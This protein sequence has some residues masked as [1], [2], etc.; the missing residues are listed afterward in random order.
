MKAEIGEFQRSML[1]LYLK[2]FDFLTSQVEWLEAKLVEHM[3]P[4]AQQVKLLD[5]IPGID[6]I[7]AWNLLAE[8]GPDM[9]V[10]PD[11][12]HCASWAGLSPGTEESAGVQRSGR[13]TKGNRYLRRILTQAAWANSHCKDGYL[14]TFFF[15]VKARR[16]W[17]RA[18][19]AVAHKLLVIAYNMLK[20]GEAYKELG[21]DY[22][23]RLHPERTAMRLVA[24]LEK[25]GYTFAAPPI[26][27]VRTEPPRDVVAQAELDPVGKRK[28]GRPRKTVA[29]AAVSPAESIG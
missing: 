10:F 8:L 25:M 11:A 24:R 7:V 9:S 5:S 3:T 29:V 1:T 22:F 28:R 19:V 14:R 20:T 15:R 26:P 27:P 18:I 17:G 2:Q 21:G 4:Y 16:G 13:T 6:Q 12:A 23:D